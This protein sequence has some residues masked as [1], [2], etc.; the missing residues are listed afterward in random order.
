MTPN[1]IM[2]SASISQLDPIWEI[3]DAAIERRRE[4]GSQQWQDGYPNREIIQNDM[5]HGYAQIWQQEGKVAAYAAAIDQPDPDYIDI[6]GA[7]LT[8]GSYLV[9]HRIAVS[10]DFLNR[11]LATQVMKDLESVALE[12]KLPSIR[13]DTSYDNPA[14]QR[15]FEKL[16]YT[17]C[18]TIRI[19]G[20]KRLAFEKILFS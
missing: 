8:D 12:K 9:I 15:V 11:G 16:G 3:F 2:T 6:E 19:R 5:T 14:M 10:P 4:E 17:H 7:W 13:V 1:F 18:G 20:K